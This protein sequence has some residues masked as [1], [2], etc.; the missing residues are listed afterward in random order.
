MSSFSTRSV[1][2]LLIIPCLQSQAESL[3][4]QGQDVNHDDV[5]AF[6]SSAWFSRVLASV[7]VHNRKNQHSSASAYLGLGGGS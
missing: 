4:W 2:L 3:L 5:L 6:L 7:W 1:C